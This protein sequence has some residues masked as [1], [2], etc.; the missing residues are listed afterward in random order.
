MNCVEYWARSAA[1]IAIAVS[2]IWWIYSAV[3]D[4]QVEDLRLIRFYPFG[5]VVIANYGNVEVLITDI[6]VAPIGEKQWKAHMPDIN[7]MIGPGEHLVQSIE[8]F[9]TFD[10]VSWMTYGNTDDVHWSRAKE[11]AL[12][13]SDGSCYSLAF[14]LTED[15]Y[16]KRLKEL[17]NY[18]IRELPTVGYLE[19]YSSSKHSITRQDISTT[20]TIVHDDSQPQC[21]RTE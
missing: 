5:P 13:G 9:L 11:E 14:F 7:V 16:W 6:F 2:A 18:K 10:K 8:K 20:G 3:P 1:G 19:Y 21:K 4:R 12:G 17:L 15:P